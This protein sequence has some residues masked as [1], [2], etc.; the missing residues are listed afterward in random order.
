MTRTRIAPRRPAVTRDVEWSTG[1]G[2]Q[3]FS[4]TLGYD[5][6]TGQLAEVFY[7]DGQ[8]VGSQLQHEISDGC[9][10]IS[11]LLQHGATPAEIGRSLSRVPVMGT[12]QPASVIGAIAKTLAEETISTEDPE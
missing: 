4:L 9:V 3:F 6:E 12:D 11:L 1:N 5:P 10:L 2:S 7:S 8:R